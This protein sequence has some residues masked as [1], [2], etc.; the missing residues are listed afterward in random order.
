MFTRAGN[1]GYE[2]ILEKLKVWRSGI[3]RVVA[4]GQ[5]RVLAIE[6]ATSIFQNAVSNI[7]RELNESR[8]LFTE[9]QSRLD[10][11]REEIDEKLNSLNPKVNSR[12]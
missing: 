6:T 7:S 8:I 4:Q 5:D 10:N 12:L 2:L 11:M 9:V 1:M 3:E